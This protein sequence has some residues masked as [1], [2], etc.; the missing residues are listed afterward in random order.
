MNTISLTGNICGELE[1]KTTNNG[2]SVLQFDLAVK[3]PYTKD[4]TDFIRLVVW[5]Q[6]AEYLKKYA[7]KGSKI[8][9]VG[10]LTTRKY[11]D[12]TGNKRTAYEVVCDNVELLDSK[13][14]GEQAAPSIPESTPTTPIPNFEEVTVDGDLPF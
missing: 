10:K 11:E 3:R 13:S 9:V 4:T 6:S 5:E 7:R 8:G 14:D 2:K 12:K 1:L